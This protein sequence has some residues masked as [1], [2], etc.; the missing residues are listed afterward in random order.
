LRKRWGGFLVVLILLIIAFDSANKVRQ[1]QIEGLAV[2]VVDATTL[3]FGSRAEGESFSWSVP[4]ENHSIRPVSISEFKTSCD[5]SSVEPSH[6]DLSPGQRGTL[7]LNIRT[8]LGAVDSQSSRYS[9]EVRGF[10][11]TSDGPRLEL[12]TR[13]AGRTQHTLNV[14]PSRLSYSSGL[15]VG[16][17]SIARQFRVFS[18]IPIDKLEA[19][20]DLQTTVTLSRDGEYYLGTVVLRPTS[21]GP[22]TTSIKLAVWRQG[23]QQPDTL[24]V[25]ISGTVL[26]NVAVDSPIHHFG[27]IEVGRTVTKSF[28]IKCAPNANLEIINWTADEAIKTTVP[29]LQS[30][31]IIVRMVVQKEGPQESILRFTVREKGEIDSDITIRLSAHG[32][33]HKGPATE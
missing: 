33:A 27:P 20:G 23:K 30:N 26:G 32:L 31:T 16:Q 8:R 15:S 18:A 21:I 22:L 4:I 2:I 24:E 19:V 6:L 12:F 28:Q 9:I 13:I 17:T 14:Q 1:F 29:S 5:C 7:R 10:S 3:N 11:R 25:P